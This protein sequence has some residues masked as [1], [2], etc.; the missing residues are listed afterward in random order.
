MEQADIIIADRVLC[1]SP[2]PMEIMEEILQYN[3]KYIVIVQP[4][5]NIIIRKLLDIN[6]TL[7]QIRWRVK[8]TNVAIP[9]VPVKKYDEF[10]AASKFSQVLQRFRY[11]WEVVIYQL[12]E[13]N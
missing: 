4:R 3:P 11:S 9:F 12:Q 1:C 2:V 10:L 7:K 13:N 8:G 6:I 5:K